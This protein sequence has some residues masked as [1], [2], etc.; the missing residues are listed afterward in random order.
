MEVALVAKG[1]LVTLEFMVVMVEAKVVLWMA[2]VALWVAEVGLAEVL[3]AMA[4]E[5]GW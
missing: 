5:Q 1:V 2:E 3:E 4:K